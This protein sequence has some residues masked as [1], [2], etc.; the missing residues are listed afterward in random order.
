MEKTRLKGDLTALYNYLKGS[1]GKVGVGLFSHVTSD[2]TTENGLT[3]HQGK[4]RLAVG[5]K[6]SKRVVRH[7]SGLPREVVESLT[8]EMFK[9]CLHVVLRDIV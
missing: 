8:L 7:W 9:K 1:C 5:K 2:K 3:L 4:Y 6:F